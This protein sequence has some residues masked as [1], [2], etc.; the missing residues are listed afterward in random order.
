MNDVLF[1]ALLGVFIT[2]L[3]V[4]FIKNYKT[5]GILYIEEKEEKDNYLFSIKDLDKLSNKKW[6]I[7][8]VKK[9]IRDYI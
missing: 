4:L 3:I 9:G 2:T 6:I 1:G 8:R 7:L 5:I